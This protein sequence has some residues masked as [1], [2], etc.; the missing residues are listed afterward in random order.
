MDCSFNILRG[1]RCKVSNDVFLF[2]KI[3]LTLTNSADAAAFYLCLHCL[4]KFYR[5]LQCLSKL[6]LGLHCL[7]NFYRGLPCLSKFYHGLHCLSRLYLGL[8]YLSIFIFAFT[9]KY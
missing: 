4:S 3:I 6:Y 5:G 2:L 7:S 8:H 1:S 9:A